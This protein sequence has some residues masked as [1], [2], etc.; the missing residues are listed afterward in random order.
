[1]DELGADGPAAA[2]AQHDLGEAAHALP[3]VG[4]GGPTGHQGGRGGP[5]QPQLVQQPRGGGQGGRGRPVGL[6]GAALGG[7]QR[8]QGPG[9]ALGPGG[10]DGVGG[11]GAPGRDRPATADREGAYGRGHIAAEQ[12]DR[13]AVPEGGGARAGGLVRLG[14]R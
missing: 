9:E 1:M 6:G 3:L 14:D 2:A 12:G 13:A 7:A 8:G 10:G 4:G 11:G 5:G